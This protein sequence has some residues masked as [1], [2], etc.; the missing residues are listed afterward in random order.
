MSA[1]WK[2][3]QDTGRCKYSVSNPMRKETATKIKSAPGND[4]KKLP[5]GDKVI[6]FHDVQDLLY[7]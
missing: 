3:N 7:C 6:Q 4:Q 5:G 2:E 1:Y